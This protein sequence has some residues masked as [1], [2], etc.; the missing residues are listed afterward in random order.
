MPRRSRRTRSRNVLDIEGGFGDRGTRSA[1][2]SSPTNTVATP[3]LIRSP[4]VGC[5]RV[6]HWRPNKYPRRSRQHLHRGCDRRRR[7]LRSREGPGPLIPRL[8]P[9][10]PGR[11]NGLVPRPRV[12]SPL[13]ANLAPHPQ[14]TCSS[15][16][17]TLAQRSRR[18]TRAP[19][20]SRRSET[21]SLRIERHVENA[22]KVANLASS[23]N[24]LSSALVAC[25]SLVSSPLVEVIGG[26]TSGPR[27]VPGPCGRLRDQAGGVDAGRQ[28]VLQADTA[29]PRC[30]QYRRRSRLVI[31]PARLPHS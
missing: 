16:F 24:S 9:A 14:G 31:H 1:P 15:R 23:A 21:L 6:V 13:G 11:Y 25:A 2:R 28:F 5:R 18:S 29:Q 3:Y 10:R 26:V 12:G 4:R 30:Q 22:V 19:L 8:Q 7:H 20:I 27:V 17:V